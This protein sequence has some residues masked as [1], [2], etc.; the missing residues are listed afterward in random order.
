VGRRINNANYE[1]D[2]ELGG[3]VPLRGLRDRLFFFGTFN[4]S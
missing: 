1:G 3:Y 2:F 4:P